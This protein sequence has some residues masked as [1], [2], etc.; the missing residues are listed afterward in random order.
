MTSPDG[1][2][3]GLVS[4]RLEERTDVIDFWGAYHA[5]PWASFYLGQMKIPSTAEVLTPDH[6]TDFIARAT[7]NKRVGDYSLSATPFT[8]PFL[9]VRTY[10]RDLGAAFKGVVP[11][12]DQPI[13]SYF[14]MVGN[15]LGG[16][17]FIGGEES[18]E[19]IYTNDFGEYFYGVR[20]DGY[21]QDWLRIGGHYNINR[22]NKIIIQDKKTTADL[23][24]T[25]WSGDLTIKLPIGLRIEGFY[26]EGR[27]EDF[28]YSQDSIFD[29]NGWGVWAVQSLFDDGLQ[30][31][32]RYDT[33]DS[34]NQDDFDHTAQ[35]NW[36]FGINL[37]PSPWLRFQFNYVWK[38][39]VNE[40]VDDTKDD[41]IY[42]N[43]Q[44]IFDAA[45][46][47]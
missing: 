16:N 41:I 19:F 14:L 29:Y 7:F 23:E 25:S 11:G 8:S 9:G 30:F 47:P 31:L 24:R 28:W 22:H 33:Y 40:L 27:I 13:F 21:L 2:F 20:L 37:R 43:V 4:L 5:A 10:N 17:T 6:L 36:S 42:V 15:G 44:Y 12:P 45:L 26:G 46:R 3:E 32:V 34:E 35:N 38:D 1:R 18:P 39:T